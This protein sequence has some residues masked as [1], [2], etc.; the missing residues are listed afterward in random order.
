[1]LAAGKLAVRDA[2]TAAGCVLAIN[3][4]AREKRKSAP[5]IRGYG[6]VGNS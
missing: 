3:T 1:M 5:V 2:K 6:I 4:V